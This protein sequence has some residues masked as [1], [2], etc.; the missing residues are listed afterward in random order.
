MSTPHPALP[1]TTPESHGLPSAAVL[2]WLDR[3]D[4]EGIELH[5]LMLLR[6]GHILAEGWWA[7]YHRRGLQLVYSLSKA[8][9]S[10]A[11][12]HAVAEGLVGL[13]DRLVDLF[14]EAAAGAGPRA[15]G[16]TLHDALSMS[17]GHRVD[18]L[19]R[20][21]RSG[22]EPVSAYLALEPES[23]RGTWFVY[24]NG[25]TF[26]AGAA[27]Q[28]ASGQRLL[29]YLRPRVLDP[30]GVGAAAWTTTPDGRDAGFSGIHV[31]TEA[32]ARLGQL[33][34][35][36]G[37]WQGRRVLPEG[38]VARASS[39]LTDNSMHPGGVDW[40]Q[41]YGYQLWRCRHGAYRG[42][43][44]FGQFCLVLPEQQG[45]LATTAC[46]EDMQGV[47]DAFW[48]EVLPAYADE[49]LADD[50]AAH[51]QLQQ[52][53]AAAML[54]VVRSAAA[55]E[56]EGPWRFAHHPAPDLE[57]GDL[58][59]GSV[60]VRD[61]GAGSWELVVDSGGTVRVPCADGDWPPVATS[62]GS[63][64]F[65]ASGGWTAPGVF[66]ARV[67]AVETPHSL[68]LR[69]ADGRVEARWS[70]R[71]LHSPRLADQRAPLT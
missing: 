42:D 6:H 18:T 55:P 10:C 12:G 35:D 13:D 11:V 25:A 48:E 19:D 38:W 69:C 28:Q 27:V 15:G 49:P 33:L 8:F 45:V 64:P 57:D 71:P 2:A 32:I 9:T 68:L 70:G 46:T 54:P 26:V 60:E 37:V 1:R 65:V 4:R 36:D 41:G 5:S 58:E 7:P 39:P 51:A 20:V 23:E 50:A 24:D 52:R 47:L 3:L 63:E 44:A 59:L 22:Q 66:E 53:L 43:G 30:I 62:G 56:G 40:Q 67:V 31:R 61:L 16:L 29:D 34:L 14:P 21:L 17:T